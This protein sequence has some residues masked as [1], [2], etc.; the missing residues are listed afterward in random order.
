[1]YSMI[2][3]KDRDTVSRNSL[4][5]RNFVST[6]M[7]CRSWEFMVHPHLSQLGCP[8]VAAC[9][10]ESAFVPV[11]RSRKISKA[12]KARLAF[13]K[14]RFRTIC[15]VFRP[16]KLIACGA[17]FLLFLHTSPLLPLIQDPNHQARDLFI[18]LEIDLTSHLSG[19]A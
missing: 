11:C 1:M 16:Y 18:S 13:S 14:Q 5:R 12:Y 19:P 6:Q 15:W 8:R 2:L 10:S 3:K 7:V 9:G 17:S 4:L